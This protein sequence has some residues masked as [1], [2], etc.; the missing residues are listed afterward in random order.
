MTGSPDSML[1]SYRLR[2]FLGRGGMSDVWEGWDSALNRAVAI[3]LYLGTQDEDLQRF[4]REARLAAQLSPPNIVP[5]FEVGEDAGRHYIVMQKIEGRTL[6]EVGLTREQIVVALRD[7]AR[8]LHYGHQKDVLHRDVKPQNI[9][10]EPRRPDADSTTD[11]RFPFRA[12]LCDFGLA[13]RLQDSGPTVTGQVIGTPA[14][15]SPEQATAENDRIGPRS[16]VYG[17]GATFYMALTG[18]LPFDRADHI[19]TL[20]AVVEEDPVRPRDH[21]AS[22]PEE[23]ETITLKAMA[24]EPDDRYATAAAFADDLDR[25]LRGDPIQ[26]LP[27]SMASRAM[28]RI[29]RHR[30]ILSGLAI[31]A[32]LLAIPLVWLL[33]RDGTLRLSIQPPDA[34]VTVDGER[35]T[36]PNIE[37]A[38][39][40]HT[41]TVEREG[42]RPQSIEVRVEPGA[43]APVAVV[44]ARRTGG[45]DLTTEPE[46]AI[47][48]F[49]EADGNEV[50]LRAP[51]SLPE[52]PAGNAS[53][54]IELAGHRRRRIDLEIPDG[55]TVRRT[56][57][58][59]SSL[60]WRQ[61][62]EGAISDTPSIADLDHDGAPDLL[63]AAD[64][65][66]LFRL[67]LRSGDV[68]W[69]RE[70]GGSIFP[71]ILAVPLDGDGVD[72]VLVAI[73][74]GGITALDGRTG[75]P[76][77]I[78]EDPHV[79]AL[80]AHV[81]DVNGD[82]VADFFTVV[83]HGPV[84]ARS[85]R[86]AGAELWET[87]MPEPGVRFADAA[88]VDGDGT[89]DLVVAGGDGVVRAVRPADG[90]IV[91]VM[92]TGRSQITTVTVAELTGAS[93]PEILVTTFDGFVDCRT[94]GSDERLWSVTTQGEV[95]SRP[96][97]ADAVV[98]IGSGDGTV[99][100]V[101]G[102]SGAMLWKSAMR[103]EVHTTPRLAPVLADGAKAVVVGTDENTVSCLDPRTGRQIWVHPTH[104]DLDASPL[105]IDVDGDGIEDIIVASEDRSVY[106]LSVEEE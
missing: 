19:R 29:H 81:E 90:S 99:Y 82:G 94:W 86:D 62:L 75:E 84:S 12:Y 48:W 47:V 43:E 20:H 30:V 16:D 58:L 103:D 67:D 13:R 21:D 51:L 97:I 26:A 11:A 39:G 71:Q 9:M 102:A 54:V 34:F 3:K 101:D 32:A 59:R 95:L 56:V 87:A 98:L 79:S 42:Y 5:V 85:G 60:I 45:L 23:L 76:I 104:D 22:I 24:K 78:L 55:E 36:G 53:A 33:L 96:G 27:P 10:I 18:Q 66:T 40:T 17:L 72:D 106:A 4:I 2:R 92:G 70:I 77:F 69:R 100:A 89:V 80:V 73:D 15:A 74:G 49:R 61:R 8:A 14:F 63:V 57:T 88:D 68:R 64:N 6:V 46:G 35:V 31:G 93:P 38:R 25:Y 44:L 7:V 37:L 50:Q 91:G 65:G 1:G 41:L 28:R 105:T 52:T 83:D